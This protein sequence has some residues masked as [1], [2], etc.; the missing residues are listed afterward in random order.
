MK[1]KDKMFFG[2]INK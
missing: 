2:K 1:T